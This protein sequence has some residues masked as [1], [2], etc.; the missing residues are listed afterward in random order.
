MTYTFQELNINTCFKFYSDATNYIGFCSIC[1]KY[2]SIFIKYETSEVI[3]YSCKKHYTITYLHT[4][5]IIVKTI[6]L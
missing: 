1:E 3:C 6:K 5:C 4:T 2:D